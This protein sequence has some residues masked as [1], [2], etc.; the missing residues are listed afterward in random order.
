MRFRAGIAAGSA[1][2]AGTLFLAC[3][4][5]YY[6]YDPAPIDAGKEASAADAGLDAHLSGDARDAGDALDPLDA[7]DA[8]DEP[9]ALDPLD[10]ADARDD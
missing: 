4:P 2:L 6:F 10:A 5:D 7:L 9:D 8:A 3:F 1:I